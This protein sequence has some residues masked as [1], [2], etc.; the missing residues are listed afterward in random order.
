MLHLA[1]IQ[2]NSTS[3]AL[4]LKL[5]ACQK[6][7]RIWHIDESNSLPLND[8]SWGEG[9]LVL[10]ECG[11]QG[12]VISVKEAKELILSLLLDSNSKPEITPQFVAQ[13]QAK[14]ERWR[15]EI[16]TQSLELNRR[17]LEIETRREQL[18]E[19]EQVLK[20][21]QEKLSQQEERGQKLVEELKQKQ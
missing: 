1:Q 9:V 13:E 20:Q 7:E 15:Q 21:D 10:V 18:Q 14:V 4:E 6:S 16:T 11:N 8:N 19:L 5:I 3:G 12:Q 2:Q 17:A